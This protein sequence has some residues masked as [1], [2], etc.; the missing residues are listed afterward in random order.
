MKENKKTGVFVND[1]EGEPISPPVRPGRRGSMDLRYY[2]G[3]G[4]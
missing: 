3:W 2:D 4:G 1:V